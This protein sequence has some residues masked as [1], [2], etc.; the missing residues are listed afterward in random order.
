MA[1]LNNG[2]LNF[3][4]VGQQYARSSSSS[5]LVRVIPERSFHRLLDGSVQSYH[6]FIHGDGALT[7]YNISLDINRR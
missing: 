6:S 7:I 5:L 3:F 4:L 2:N 1:L